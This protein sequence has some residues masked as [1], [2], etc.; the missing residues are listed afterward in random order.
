[1]RTIPPLTFGDLLSTPTQYR[2]PSLVSVSSVDH[3]KTLLTV[4]VNTLTGEAGGLFGICLSDLDATMNST[5]TGI[6]TSFSWKGCVRLTALL[7]EFMMRALKVPKCVIQFIVGFCTVGACMK[8][9]FLAKSC[10]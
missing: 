7:D 9:P 2:V 3:S 5:T 8:H 4:V 10:F 6:F 1:M